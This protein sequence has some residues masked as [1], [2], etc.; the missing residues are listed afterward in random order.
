[1]HNPIII[2]NF[3]FK[4][5][6]ECNNLQ[7]KKSKIELVYMKIDISTKNISS[8]A[9]PRSARDRAASGVSASDRATIKAFRADVVDL[10][11]V[12]G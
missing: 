6:N 12:F 1:M 7:F 5:F 3:Q 10:A 9:S 4:I 11:A 8:G 2:F